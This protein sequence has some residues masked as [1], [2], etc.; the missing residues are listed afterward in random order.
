[1]DKDRVERAARALHEVLSAPGDEPWERLPVVDA[2]RRRGQ[3]LAVL[4]AGDEPEPDWKQFAKDYLSGDSERM[5][6]RLPE[7]PLNPPSTV[8]MYMGHRLTRRHHAGHWEALPEHS[9]YG[10]PETWTWA[11]I[12]PEDEDGYRTFYQ[13]CPQTWAQHAGLEKKSD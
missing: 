2:D 8:H 3:A 6:A 4:T 9:L 5:R 12:C 1:M 13:G 11:C 10:A 7:W